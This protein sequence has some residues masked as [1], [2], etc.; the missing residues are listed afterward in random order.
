VAALSLA[1]GRVTV[2]HGAVHLVL[3]AAYLL[4]TIVP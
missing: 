3:F 2:L 4:V 1:R